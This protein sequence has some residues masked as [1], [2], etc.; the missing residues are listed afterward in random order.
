M[1]PIARNLL[2]LAA[3]STRLLG[4]TSAEAPISIT[5]P[6]ED[7]GWRVHTALYGWAQALDGEVGIGR[8]EADVSLDFKDILENLDIA[9]MGMIE[10]GRGR[11]SLLADFNYAEISDSVT[12]FPRFPGFSVDF[13]QKQFLGNFLVTYNVVDCS[14]LKLDLMAG[15]RVNWI[16]AELDLRRKISRDDA[17]ADPVVGARF[18]MPIGNGFF[19]RAAGDI[20][21]F[22]AASDLTWQALAGVGWNFRENSAVVLAYRAIG[23][24]YDNG[25]FSYDMTAQGPLLGLEFRF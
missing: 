22:G 3:C 19:F 5:P 8:L 9:A 12:P 24:D 7:G 1:Q 20:G 14:E 21:G 4:G 13:E 10:V 6:A 17:W 2:I 23:T 11:W 25:N 18:Q 15:T 16:D